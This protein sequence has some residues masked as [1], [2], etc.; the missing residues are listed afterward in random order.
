MVVAVWLA[1]QE[2]SRR[3]H[4][5]FAVTLLSVLIAISIRWIE[6]LMLIA[7][8]LALGGAFWERLGTVADG[9]GPLGYGVTAAFI[10]IW[11][12][13]YFSFRARA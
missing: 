2:P 10:F 7:D 3:L 11:M 5:N 9:L 12:A 4:Y 1:L 6:A 13:S 8:K